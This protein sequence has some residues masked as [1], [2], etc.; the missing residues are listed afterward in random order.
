M[1]IASVLVN[2]DIDDDLRPVIRENEVVAE[3]FT[4]V[5]VVTVAIKEKLHI[6]EQ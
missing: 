2:N 4:P 5:F 1:Y 3:A 6:F